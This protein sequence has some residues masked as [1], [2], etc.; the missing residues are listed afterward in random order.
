[1]CFINFGM[2]LLTA[3]SPPSGS[4]HTDYRDTAYIFIG[5]LS[6]DLSEGD[7][8]T[9]F[10]QFG[11]PT[12]IKLQRDKETGKSRGFAFLKYEDQRSCDL[13]VD[14]L[15]GATVLGRT[16][17]VDHSR[18][19]KREGEEKEDERYNIQFD[20]PAKKP[21]NRVDDQGSD[22]EKEKNRRSPTKAEKELGELIRNHDDDD[23]M[24]EYLINEKKEEI[25][26]EFEAMGRSKRESRHRHKHRHERQHR[27]ENRTSEKTKHGHRSRD[28]GRS[29]SPEKSDRRR[30][31]E[32]RHRYS[33][34]ND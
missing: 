17:R 11:V 28:R 21:G 33:T 8:E 27:D 18:Y 5:G 22:S 31:R 25:A 30:S 32:R 2:S 9:I 34:K 6:F 1:M 23:P 14:N 26:A 15:G 24:K 29:T 13:A 16:L 3:D 20:V 12:W 10:S 19:K 4:W 7:I